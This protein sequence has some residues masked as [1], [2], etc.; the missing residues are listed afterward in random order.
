M[1]NQDVIAVVGVG[2]SLGSAVARRFAEAGFTVALL[3]R[4][5]STTGPL[6]RELQHAGYEAAALEMDATVPDSVEHAFAEIDN[7]F[8]S[9]PSVLVY[10]AGIFAIGHV[11]DIAPTDFERSWRINCMGGFLAAKAA[12]GPMLDAGRGTIIF[13]GATASLR[14]GKGFANL[15]VGKFGLRALAQSLARE[16]GPQG[17]H[18][19]HAIIDGQI[20][21][22]AIR[23]RQPERE[24]HT[25]L[26]PDAIAETY[27]ALHRQD[28]TAWTLEL[29]LRPAVESF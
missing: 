19:A 23:E 12:V 13:T 10:N 28:G 18:V 14:G 3:A 15:A 26:A 1:N 24:T 29:D 2:P 5:T 4:G 17:V 27:L 16:V 7:R 21:T 8:G 20:D 6:A 11:A 25:L 9:S 22:P